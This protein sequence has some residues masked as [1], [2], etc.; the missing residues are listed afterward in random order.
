MGYVGLLLSGAALFLNSLVILGK[1]EMKSAGVFNL[2]VGALQI[3]IPFYLIMI[4]DQS[5][6]T[7]YSYAATFLFGLTYLYVGVT[8]IKGMDSSGLGWFCIWVAI[9]ALFYMV[10]SF[11]QFNDV[12][13]ALTWFMWAL[14]WYL[15]F[16]LNTQKK[17]INQYLGRIAFV[18][19]WVTLTLP[20]LFYFM[21]VWGEG[22]VYELW[23]YVSVISILYFCYCIFKY[24]VR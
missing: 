24:R 23:V 15:F 16:V 21:G 2:F 8:F 13:N 14:L 19:S 10:V 9:I 20:S 7:V 12:V 4:S 5:N 11:V 3:I 17:N 1:A 6:W 22:F 18:Q